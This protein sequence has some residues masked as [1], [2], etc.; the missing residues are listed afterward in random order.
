MQ[1]ITHAENLAVELDAHG[2]IQDQVHLFSKAEV[3]AVNAALAVGR[4]LLVRGEPGVGKSQLARAAAK[5][6]KRV[7]VQ[8]VVDS[9]TESRDLLWR[10]DSLGRLAEAQLAGALRE[11]SLEAVRNRLAPENFVHPGPIWWAFDW[12]GAHKQAKLSGCCAPEQAQDADAGNGSVVLIDEIDKAE[13]E[14]PNGL[15]EALGSGRFTP[16]GNISPVGANPELPGPLVII[17]TNEDRALP[18]AFLRRCLVLRLELPDGDALIDLLDERGK[19]HF[20][21]SDPAVRR[22][23]ARQLVD[24]RKKTLAAQERPL[25]GQAEYFDLLRAVTTLHESDVDAQLAALKEVALY[26]TKK[27]GV[28]KQDGD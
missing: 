3:D 8:H 27:H 10:L 20:R 26:V 24:D 9:Q 5:Y 6:L 4:P 7:F 19:A 22:E 11:E 28:K 23:A 18:D 25:P 21:N 13:S 17:T 15:L 16:P 14:V 12:H 1:F 2:L